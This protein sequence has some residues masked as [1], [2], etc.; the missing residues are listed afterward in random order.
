MVEGSLYKVDWK[1]DIKQRKGEKEK[2]GESDSK[3][4]QIEAGPV[5]ATAENLG[6]AA[7]QNLIIRLFAI[8][9]PP[10]E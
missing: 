7:R 4:A 10:H 1:K 3:S 2:K 6:H 5:S 8:T 9:G